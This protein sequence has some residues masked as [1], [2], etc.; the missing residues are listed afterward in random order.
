MLL[1]QLLSFLFETKLTMNYIS[2]VIQLIYY[3]VNKEE[4][5]KICTGQVSFYFT[6]FVYAQFWNNLL[7]RDK[8]H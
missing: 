3:F 2:K 5:F 4:H 8:S 6:L 1:L 7:C